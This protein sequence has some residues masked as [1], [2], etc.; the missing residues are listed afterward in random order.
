MTPDP[1]LATVRALPPV[2]T[3]RE[4]AAVIRLSERTIR[5]KLAMG[6]FPIP[7]LGDDVHRWRFA[8]ADVARYLNRPRRRVS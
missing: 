7:P 8:G 2:L 1:A 4:L 3:L 6:T 5:G